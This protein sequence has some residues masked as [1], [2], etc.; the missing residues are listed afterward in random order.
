[1][2]YLSELSEDNVLYVYH[3]TDIGV[4]I[5]TV[6][7]F[8]MSN[9]FKMYP[10]RAFPKVKIVEESVIKFDFCGFI[11]MLRDRNHLTTK[12][13]SDVIHTASILYENDIRSLTLKI[14][15]LLQLHP[16]FGP[17][18]DVIIDLVPFGKVKIVE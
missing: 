1:M 5:M 15:E 16:A 14:N 17:T 4:E 11:E 7:D 18:D 12:W 8:L 2:K 9:Y 3:N 13:K 10:E 6:K